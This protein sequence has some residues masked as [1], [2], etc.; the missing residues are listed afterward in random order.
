MGDPDGAEHPGTAVGHVESERVVESKE[1]AESRRDVRL[2]RRVVRADVPRDAAGDEEIDD[3][4][5]GLIRHLLAD[6]GRTRHPTQPSA[7]S[8]RVHR[9]DEAACRQH[10]PKLYIAGVP[11]VPARVPCASA[12]LFF[13]GLLEGLPC[14]DRP[15]YHGGAMTTP[16]TRALASEIDPVRFEVIR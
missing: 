2:E 11:C 1:R 8:L 15:R 13:G 16:T 14:A 10:G 12:C 6:S 3:H 7:T 9:P 4:V 5:A